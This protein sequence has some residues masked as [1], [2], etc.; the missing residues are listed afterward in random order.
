MQ[1]S[2]FDLENRYASLSEAGDPLERLNAV[3]DWEIF[4]PILARIDAKERKTAAGRK[5]TC[6]VL[7]FMS[8]RYGI[9]WGKLLILQRLHNLSDERLQYQVSDRLSFMRFLGL[10]L[11]GNVP[12]ARTVWAFREVLK[13]H[14]LTDA[15][16]HDSQALDAV[17]RKEDEGGK[18][19]W[20]DSAYRSNEQEQSLKD[21]RH[22]SRI[23]ER[24]YRNTPLTKAQEIS[25]TAKSRVRARVE[26]VFGHMENTMGGVF[27]RLARR[28]PRWAWA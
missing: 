17:L 1:S 7:M 24:A 11:S 2:L 4:R 18:A 27:L 23:H 20:A 19:V 26:P 3:I 25:N 21:S 6:R 22:E 28:V 15:G 13:E 5:P 16:V 8:G 10:E 12:D 14:Q 9:P